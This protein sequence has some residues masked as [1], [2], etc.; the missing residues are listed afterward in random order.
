MDRWT[1]R[2]FLQEQQWIWCSH[3]VLGVPLSPSCHPNPVFLGQLWPCQTQDW[4]CLG[5]PSPALILPCSG[6]HPVMGQW[7][8]GLWCSPLC[9]QP[10][11]GDSCCIPLMPLRLSEP[12]LEEISALIKKFGETTAWTKEKCLHWRVL[13]WRFY[14][15]VHD[16]CLCFT[17]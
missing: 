5:T 11:P 4:F 2:G 7:L 14:T 10:G 8:T 1:R 3:S 15:A 17:K 9:C 13:T 16:L 6:N 12:S